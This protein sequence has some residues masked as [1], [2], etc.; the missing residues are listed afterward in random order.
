MAEAKEV[1]AEPEPEGG[2]APKAEAAAAKKPP[3]LWQ[4]AHVLDLVTLER[5]RDIAA[6]AKSG[7]G[8][9]R[10]ALMAHMASR[11]GRPKAGRNASASA[12]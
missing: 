11:R 8:S 3:K 5:S 12:R 9:S 1:K 2:A 6:A 7:S 4:P 10:N